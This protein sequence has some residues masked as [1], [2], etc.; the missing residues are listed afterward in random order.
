MGTS[1]CLWFK[2]YASKESI[3]ASMLL[4]MKEDN[5]FECDKP[6]AWLFGWGNSED[7][8]LLVALQRKY[9]SSPGRST[10]FGKW[11]RLSRRNI[12]CSSR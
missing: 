8:Q 3:K 11:E 12:D 1:L 4:L 6:L 10:F 2:A 7:L 5:L 9:K